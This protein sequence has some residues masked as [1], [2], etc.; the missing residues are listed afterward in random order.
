MESEL[1]GY[2]RGAFT[3]AL[4]EGKLGLV[5]LASEGT[6]FFDE[7]AELTIHLQSKILQMIQEHC[8]IPVGGEAVKHVDVR[9][10]A[11]TN[12]NLKEMVANNKFRED[13]YYRLLYC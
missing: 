2:K 6:L 3:G 13:L 4:K 1:F 5:E 9:I 11:A 7:V 12:R 8:F 10:I